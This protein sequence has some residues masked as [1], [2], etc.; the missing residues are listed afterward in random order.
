MRPLALAAAASLFL[1]TAAPGGEIVGSAFTSGNWEG[2][3]YTFDDTGE[4]SHCA[5]S[6]G[7]VNGDYLYLS[8]NSD[9][10]VTVGVESPGFRFRPNES[11][12]VSLHIDNRRP[13]NGTA[14]A[15]EETFIIVTIH[16]FQGAMRALTQGRGLR[17]EGRTQLGNFDLTGSYRA[18]EAARQC[19]IDQLD[20]AARGGVP[21]TLAP[22]EPAA[23][24]PPATAAAPPATDRTV[25]FQI[26]TEMIS[27]IGAPRF[28]YLDA[29]ESREI[30]GQEAVF[31]VSEEA[32]IL[33]GV[34]VLPLEGAA[35]RESDPG[36]LS[37]VS[38]DCLGDV[39]TTT[40]SMTLEGLEA[41]EIRALCV[42]AEGNVETILTK[43][44]VDDLAL[45]TILAFGEGA[46]ADSSQARRQLSESVALRAASYVAGSPAQGGGKTR[47]VAP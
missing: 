41:R 8:V 37:F 4:F 11:F 33:G 22:S 19:A 16:D 36:D 40:R 24:P 28:R 32:G 26:A 15:L 5:I 44:R 17:V 13:F 46:V 27:E 10:T 47:R 7:Y 23:P 34:V 9:A 30:A 1:A 18:L 21:K 39:A 38:A 35:L 42:E 3:A 6:V 2:A 14:T 31:W 20:F 12:P 25:L 45:Y 43:I 29:S